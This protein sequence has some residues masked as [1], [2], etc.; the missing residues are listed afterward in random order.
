MLIVAEPYFKSMETARR[1]HGLA[2]DLGLPEVN[3]VA[4]KVQPNETNVVEDY[5]K[6][7]SFDMI[8][9]VP[10]DPEFAAAD[11]A[12]DAPIDFVPDG[13]GV[14]AIRELADMLGAGS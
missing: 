8:T 9:T 5:C 6:H 1:Y 7:H 12:G 14:S 13:V 10:F 2:V 11:R 4:N 3:I